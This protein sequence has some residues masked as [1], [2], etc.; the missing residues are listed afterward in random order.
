M[1]EPIKLI[2]R[3]EAANT[4]VKKPY[5]TPTLIDMSA[6][7]NTLGKNPDPFEVGS[8]GSAIS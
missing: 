8:T 5:S 2:E 6:G 4:S 3:P 1:N 7:E